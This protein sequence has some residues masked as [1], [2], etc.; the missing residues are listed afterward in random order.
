MARNPPYISLC[1]SQ[2][3]ILIYNA[4]RRR[5]F[6]LS[7]LGLRR[8]MIGYFVDNDEIVDYPSGAHEFT[9]GF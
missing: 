8:E 1:L 2:A 4:I 6:V 7:G 9:L 5:I 3:W